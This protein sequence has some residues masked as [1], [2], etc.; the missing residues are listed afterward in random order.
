MENDLKEIDESIYEMDINK[1]I[2]EHK[3]INIEIDNE[4]EKEIINKKIENILDNLKKDV[5]IIAELNDFIFIDGDDAFKGIDHVLDVY[6]YR[7]PTHFNSYGYRLM[8]EHIKKIL[9]EQTY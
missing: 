9:D 4:I 5:K 3:R 2:D 1:E 6:H 7:Y 8:S